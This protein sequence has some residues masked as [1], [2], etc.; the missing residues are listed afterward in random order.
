ME[1]F[2]LISKFFETQAGI[3][4]AIMGLI[5]L[6]SAP[7]ITNVQATANQSLAEITTMCHGCLLIYVPF[8]HQE[9]SEDQCFYINSCLN[10]GSSIVECYNAARNINCDMYNDKRYYCPGVVLGSEY[11]HHWFELL[12]L[13]ARP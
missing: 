4:V 11:N 7:I 2:H 5:I 13:P 8:S 6:I 1:D 10:T 9:L 12:G 3:V